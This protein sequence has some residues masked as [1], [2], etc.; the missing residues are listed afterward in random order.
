M[1]IKDKYLLQI[2]FF[3]LLFKFLG[4]SGLYGPIIPIIGNFC[5]GRFHTYSYTV[6]IVSH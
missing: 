2:D 6:F 5:G 4:T 1:K 3:Q